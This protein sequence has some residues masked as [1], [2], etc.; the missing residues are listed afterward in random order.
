MTHEGLSRVDDA[1]MMV[2]WWFVMMN[3]WS[4]LATMAIMVNGGNNNGWSNMLD[5]YSSIMV[6]ATNSGWWQGITSNNTITECGSWAVPLHSFTWRMENVTMKSIIKLDIYGLCGSRA[7]PPCTPAVHAPK[8]NRTAG[9]SKFIGGRSSAACWRDEG[10][11]VVA[12]STSDLASGACR[13]R[14]WSSFHHQ[15]VYHIIR[16]VNEQANE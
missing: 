13:L 3:W 8:T 11:I 12:M 6:M 2:N 14:S 10:D 5:W 15:V 1:L 16:M 9:C 7:R 4:I